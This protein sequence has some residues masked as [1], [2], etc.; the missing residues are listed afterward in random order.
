MKKFS[1]ILTKGL[2]LIMFIGVAA[3]SYSQDASDPCPSKYGKDTVM[4]KEKLSMFNQYYKAKDYAKAYPYWRYLFDN[5]PCIQKR[6]TVNGPAVA[7]KYLIHLKKTNDSMYQV[8]KN[9]II[10][11]VLMTYPKRIEL[12]GREG[13]VIGRWAG[14]LAKL[15]P[16]RRQEALRMFEKSIEM[17]GNKTSYIVPMGYMKTAIKEHAKDHYGLDSLYRLYFQLMDITSYN[18]VNSKKAEKYK[19]TETYLNKVMKPYLNCEKVEEYF[20]PKIEESPNDTAL[21]KKVATLLVSAKCEK[22]AFFLGIAEQIYAL[23]PSPEAA[24]TI[25][26]GR[27]A[28][29]EYKSAAHWFEKAAVGAHD[30]TTM[31]KI[32]MLIAVIHDKHL[33]DL[34]AANKAASVALHLHGDLAT[35]YL[36]KAKYI[37]TLTN[38]CSSDGI[39]GMSVFWAA[40]DA[41]AKARHIAKAEGN[42]AQVEVANKL[43]SFYKSKFITKQDAFFKGFTQEEGS[44]FTVPGTGS[45]TIVRY[46]VK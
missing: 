33:H 3:T 13:Y 30:D 15:R 29:K 25:A 34:G 10:D 6:I 17:E 12:Y 21:L 22:S 18:L 39:D 43:I 11:T 28:N 40:S 38:A 20:K 37:G 5:A 45:T 41:A 36:I 26:V 4:A 14:D 31:A 16:K 35:A 8:R 24:K 9:G 44:T 46:R 23:D 19:A 42:E 2:A 27:L 32:H 7:R 1:N